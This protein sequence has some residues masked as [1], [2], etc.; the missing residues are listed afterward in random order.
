MNNQLT[1]IGLMVT[2]IVK[3]ASEGNVL[4]P[5]GVFCFILLQTALV[6]SG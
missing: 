3:V 5:S 4:Y 1:V 2:G 6:D